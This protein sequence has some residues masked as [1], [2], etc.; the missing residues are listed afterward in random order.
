MEQEQFIKILEQYEELT[1][2]R[3][4]GAPNRRES[5][6]PETIYRNGYEFEVS[7]GNNPTHQLEIKQLKH[8]PRVCE[9]CRLVVEN[10]VVSK[11]VHQYPQRHWRES[12]EPC[13]KTL[14][15]ETGQFDIDT[16]KSQSVF[17]SYFNKQNK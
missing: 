11:R 17:T 15:P 4:A 14:N 6:E 1:V 12:C 7:K 10:R 13:H 3:V 2:K 16:D 9:D 8:Q 5:T